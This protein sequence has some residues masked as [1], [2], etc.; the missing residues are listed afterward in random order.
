MDPNA[1]NNTYE[2]FLAMINQEAWGSGSGSAPRMTR[3]Y[4]LHQRGKAEQR[5]VDDYFGEDD[6]PKYPEE[7]FRRRHVVTCIPFVYSE[8]T[9]VYSR[10]TSGIDAPAYTRT[11]PPV[12]CYQLKTDNAI[13]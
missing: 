12:L 1:P 11:C 7:I 5:L 13:L 6:T 9:S 10:V 3:T 2:Q 8:A 4:I